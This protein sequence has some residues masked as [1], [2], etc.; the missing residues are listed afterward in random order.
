MSH[1]LLRIDSRCTY[2]Y[3]KFLIVDLEISKMSNT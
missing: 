1:W 2:Y 3:M